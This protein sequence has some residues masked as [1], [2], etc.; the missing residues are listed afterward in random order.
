MKKSSLLISSA[1]A[2]AVALT[3]GAK[4]GDD[5]MCTEVMHKAEFWE[6]HSSAKNVCGGAHNDCGGQVNA[7]DHKGAMHAKVNLPKEV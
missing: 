3:A 5:V 2:G 7:K 6:N 4:A 1:I